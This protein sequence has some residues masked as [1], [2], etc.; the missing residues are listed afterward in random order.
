MRIVKLNNLFW[1]YYL[2]GINVCVLINCEIIVIVFANNGIKRMK[3][4]TKVVFF[5]VGL[6]YFEI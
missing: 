4:N 1:Y 6:E 3:L 2:N 5:G